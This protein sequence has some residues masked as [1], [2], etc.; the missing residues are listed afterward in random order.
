MK[1][2]Y[3]GALASRERGS[4]AQHSFPTAEIVFRQA[5]YRTKDKQARNLICTHEPCIS[6]LPSRE[7]RRAINRLDPVAHVFPPRAPHSCARV[8]PRV[9][10]R[11]CHLMA[12][13]APVQRN[14]HRRMHFMSTPYAPQLLLLSLERGTKTNRPRTTRANLRESTLTRATSVAIAC[15]HALGTT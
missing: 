11:R 1:N 13:H 6:Y 3:Y 8:I 15:E 4:H 10:L 12:S 2:K 9:L 5:L 7:E 14:G